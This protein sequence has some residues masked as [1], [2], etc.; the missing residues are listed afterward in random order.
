[1]ACEI[2]GRPYK[3]Q[4]LPKFGV[5]LVGLFVPVLREM[6]EM[7]YQFENDFIF[8]STKFE[9]AFNIQATSYREG[10]AATLK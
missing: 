4:A 7:M 5:R 10:I 6:V 8:E 2:A 3:I 1:M 9:K